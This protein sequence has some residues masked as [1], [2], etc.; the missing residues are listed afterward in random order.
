ML[1]DHPDAYQLKAR[2]DITLW[3]LLVGINADQWS[4]RV[5]VA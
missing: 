1:R 2:H 4:A 3:L 5:G